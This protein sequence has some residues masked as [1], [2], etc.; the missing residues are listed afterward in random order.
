M[1]H[2]HDARF[3][4][5]SSFDPLTGQGVRSHTYD[6]F[7]HDTGLDPERASYPELL[8]VGIMGSCMHG[9]S[10]LCAASGVQC[11]QN[12]ATEHE[13][14]LSFEHF[15]SIVDQSAGRTFQMALGGRGDPNDHPDFL[16]MITYAQAHGIVPNFTTSGLGLREDHLPTIKAVC[17]AVA[18]SWYRSPITTQTIDR[19]S[20]A[21]IKTNIHYVLSNSTLD[22]AFTVMDQV[23][24]D[25]RI[26][27]LI[28]LLHKPVG[29]GHHDQVLSSHDPKVIRFFS[30][31]DDPSRM[32]KAGFDSCG[33][34]G[35]INSTSRIDPACI[36][37]CEAG[38]F[39]AY[40]TP[41]YRLVP[42]S[43]EK[44]P[45]YAVDLH[46]STIAQAFDSAPFN[47][48]RHRLDGHCAG[49]N[50]WLH[51]RSGCPIVEDITLCHRPNRTIQGAHV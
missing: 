46:T 41:D 33:V 2:R 45:I 47:R 17:G 34:P 22:E 9:L 35:L 37:A 48:F 13:D 31:F 19:L 6:A 43:F 50:A 26:N 14:H 18:V 20:Q 27:R 25:D 36:E 21:G 39:S 16:R 40:I 15:K 4:Y 12:G 23:L 1:I 3:R 51:C 10:G 29:Q 8:D 11:Y 42:C 49:C 32:A 38:R 5:L 30:L 24:N 7:G 28:F 44:D